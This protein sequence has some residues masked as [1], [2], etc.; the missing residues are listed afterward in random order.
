M[1]ELYLKEKGEPAEFCDGNAFID[2][3]FPY[4]YYFEFDGENLFQIVET[5]VPS[6]FARIKLDEDISYDDSS[7]V[8]DRLYKRT[9]YFDMNPQRKIVSNYKLSELINKINETN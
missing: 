3:D 6:E 2:N 4:D 9:F 8:V 7:A 5:N 1:Q